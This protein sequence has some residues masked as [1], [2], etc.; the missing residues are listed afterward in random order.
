M[1]QSRK[2]K[3][4]VIMGATGTGKSRLSVDLAT[5]FSAEIIN[6]D[7]K[8]FYSALEITTNQITSIP[9]RC[10]IPHHLLG[11]HPVDD[12]ELTASEFRS[13]VHALLVEHFDPETNPFS[14]KPSISSELSRCINFGVYPPEKNDNICEWDQAR[15]SAY[16]EAVQEIKD[17]TWLLAKKQRLRD[18]EV[19]CYCVVKAMDRALMALSLEEE[20]DEVP[21]TMP[22]LPGFRLIFTMPRKWQKEGRVRGIALSEEKWVENPPPDYLQFIPLWVQISKIPVNYYNEAALMTLG[23]M[24]REV[25]MLAYDPTKSITQP[26]IRVQVR[27]NVANP[28]K[29]ARVLDMGGGK[30]HTIHFDYEKLHKRCYTCKRLN[31]EQRFCPLEIKK[32]QDNALQRREKVRDELNKAKMVIQQND[33]LFGVLDE[34]QVGMNPN[35][36][37]PKI[38]N[39]VLEEMRRYL[40]ADTGEVMAVKVDKVKKSVRETEKDPLLQKTILRLEKA[41][42]LTADLIKGK[43]HVYDFSEKETES[44]NWDLNDLPPKL[45]WRFD[46]GNP[47]VFRA[48][49]SESGSSG[50]VGKR[51]YVR[52]R[53]PRAQ[54]QKQK[55]ILAITSGLEDEMEDRRDGKQEMGS[56]KRKKTDQGGDSWGSTLRRPMRLSSK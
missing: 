45:T 36:G 34:D 48:G 17:N 51:K 38:A 5:R 21:F 18:S 26:F 42:V 47:T 39:D 11:E 13:F 3:M 52:K 23:E 8:Q 12:S 20:E 2:D 49:F 29:M 9:E 40:L 55:P 16:E 28:L 14:S 15:T 10:G 6:S 19:G 43:G 31:H 44:R 50:I 4:V 27:F 33:P 7:K 56:R 54:R 53:P 22:T 30:T 37:R 32:R 35:T 41:P 1:D 24:L 25:I 46:E